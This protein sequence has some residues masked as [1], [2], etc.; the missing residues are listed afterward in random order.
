M[1]TAPVPPTPKSGVTR[2]GVFYAL[3]YNLTQV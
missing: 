1:A 2:R 3:A